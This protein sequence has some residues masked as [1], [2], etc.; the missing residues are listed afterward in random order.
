MSYYSVLAYFKKH[1]YHECTTIVLNGVRDYHN[2]E[3]RRKI[4]MLNTFLFFGIGF[5]QVMGTIAIVQDTYL[6]FTLDLLMSCTF[7]TVFLFLRYTGNEPIASKIG[8]IAVFIFF[9]G[10]FLYGGVAGTASLWTYTFPLLSLYL[11]G[12]RRGHRLNL[13]MFL[14]CA[15]YLIFD[16]TTDFIN[17]YSIDFSA[18][19]LPSFLAVCILA[20]LVERSRSKTVDDLQVMTDLLEVQV[21]KRTEELERLNAELVSEI[22]ERK[23]TDRENTRLQTELQQAEKLELVGK[24]AGGVAHDL[25]NVLSGIVSYPDLL[26]QEIPQDSK[27]R[28]PLEKI[29]LSGTRAASIVDD[30]LS[31]TRRYSTKKEIININKII[32]EYF[33]SPEFYNIKTRYPNIIFTHIF[34]KTPNILGAKF[35][36][37]KVLMNLIINSCEAINNTGKIT[38]YT[39]VKQKTI[40]ETN[41]ISNFV[42][43]SVVDTGSGISDENIDSIFEPFYTKKIMGRSGTGLGMTVVLGVIKDHGGYIEVKSRVKNGTTI[44]I[45]FPLCNDSV[46][47]NIDQSIS[48]SLGNNQHIL[49]IDDEEDQQEIGK[50]I[51]TTLNYKCTAVG[52]GK[53]GLKMIENNNYDLV[54]LDMIMSGLDGLQT[55]KEIKNMF[56]LLPVILVSGYAEEDSIKEARSLGADIFVKKPYSLTDISSAIYR[57]LH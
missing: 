1:V 11:L 43:L 27:I 46:V 31:L 29:K 6:L 33:E 12:A 10:L 49:I 25:N 47:N 4:S 9:I 23:N 24:L 8:V 54:L 35:H 51:L 41:T 14:L 45:Y 28:Q 39:D 19:F 56:P 30:L 15:I 52:S 13:L 48:I 16:V 3:D 53:D 42:I 7:L 36:L 5:L 57:S 34:K 20:W 50:N 18:R 22:E 32:S 37:Q 21:K 17:I 55:L 40:T 26:L 2:H 44:T 38:V